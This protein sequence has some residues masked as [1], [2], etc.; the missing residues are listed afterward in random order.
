MINFPNAQINESLNS[1][2]GWPTV[3][4]YDLNLKQNENS[5]EFHN[6]YIVIAESG[7]NYIVVLNFFTIFIL[8]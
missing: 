7:N 1:L 5:E 8:F 2:L 3:M 6:N 4:N